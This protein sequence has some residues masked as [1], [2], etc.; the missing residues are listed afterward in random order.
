MENTIIACTGILA[1]I[2]FAGLVLLSQQLT[3]THKHINKQLGVID[4]RTLALNS[5]VHRIDNKTNSVKQESP[6]QETSEEKTT[7]LFQEQ[8]SYQ[9]HRLYVDAMEG[10]LFKATGIPFLKRYKLAVNI[11]KLRMVPNI[12]GTATRTPDHFK[13]AFELEKVLG[14]P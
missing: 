1:L 5:I 8:I 14:H 3:Q 6:Q 7:Y 13:Y 9:N 4:D 11:Y 2:I 10:K 12:N